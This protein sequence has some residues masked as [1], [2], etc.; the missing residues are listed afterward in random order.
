MGYIEKQIISNS[1]I[2]VDFKFKAGCCQE[3][4]G[5]YTISNDTLNFIYE[6]VNDDLCGCLCWYKYKLQI[7]E[8]KT[9]VKAIKLRLKLKTTANPKYA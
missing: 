4:G 1:N 7:N 8:P 6:Q 2:K 9:Q 3:F 5:D